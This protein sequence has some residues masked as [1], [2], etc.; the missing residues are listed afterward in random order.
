MVVRRDQRAKHEKELKEEIQQELE[1]NIEMLG[2]MDLE[3]LNEYEKLRNIIYFWREC[4]GENHIYYEY[5]YAKR[6][7]DEILCERLIRDASDSSGVSYLSD[8]YMDFGDF[9]E[10]SGQEGFDDWFKPRAHLFGL[11]RID[12]VVSD[13]SKPLSLDD[14][15]HILNMTYDFLREKAKYVLNLPS[16]RPII[17]SLYR[18]WQ[19]NVINETLCQV[20]ESGGR[21]Y[22]E[23][24]LAKQL[25]RSLWLQNYLGFAWDLSTSLNGNYVS[26]VRRADK[27]YKSCIESTIFNIFPYG[28]FKINRRK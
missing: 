19:A 13:G 10:G 5:C 26:V 7:G 1:E 15:N 4:L 18:L 24:R 20:D 16:K 11:Q 25:T 27:F 23:Y 14:Q 17:Y 9:Y 12:I 6:S 21:Y 28:D 8:I 22:T 2:L 3:N